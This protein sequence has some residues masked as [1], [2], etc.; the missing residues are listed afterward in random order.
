[1]PELPEVEVVRRGIQQWATGSH[2]AA[3]EI[4]DPRSL[5]RHVHGPA[6][7]IARLQ[8]H[9]LGETQRRGKYLW[10]TLDEESVALV[11]HLGMSGQVLVTDPDIPDPKHLKIRII[12]SNGDRLQELRFVDQRIFGGLYLDTLIPAEDHSAELIPSTVAH[13]GRDPLDPLCSHEALFR[14]LRRKK[15]SLKRALLDQSISSGIGNIYAD[16]ALFRARLHYARPTETLTRNEVSRVYTAAEQVMRLALAQGGTSFDALYVNVNGESG[17]FDRSLY[18]YG[19]E[20]KP[21][22][23]CQK[24]GLE[25]LIVRKKF[26][27]RSS[28]YCPKCQPVPRRARW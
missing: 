5:R 23:T 13:I 16:E 19:R 12:L 2:I 3:V 1:M 17:Y 24:D 15:S 4:L 10:I 8:G 14:I 7:F 26:M 25:T 27:N 6:D 21:C 9:C 28:Y 18:V 22:L 11:V 20:G